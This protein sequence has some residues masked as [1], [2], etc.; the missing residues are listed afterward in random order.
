MALWS[1]V[2]KEIRDGLIIITLIFYVVLAADIYDRQVFW[3]TT[4][5]DWEVN[6]QFEIPD[7]FGK[8]MINCD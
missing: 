6:E 2:L 3:D 8:A 1:E 5:R 7:G 4:Y